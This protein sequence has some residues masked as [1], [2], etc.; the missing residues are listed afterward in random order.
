[1]NV[2]N[3]M[4][5]L[6]RG[7]NKNCTTFK[8]K[9]MNIRSKNYNRMLLLTTLMTVNSIVFGQR[10]TD[11][12]TISRDQQRQCIKWYN[13]MIYRDS[14]ILVKDQ[15][16]SLKDSIIDNRGAIIAEKTAMINVIEADKENL[17]RK[18]K[19]RNKIILWSGVAILIESIVIILTI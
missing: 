10:S 4:T 19:T 6:K 2:Q 1:M 14:I 7:I 12:V 9:S 17:Q 11:S 13:G 18:V 3:L 8:T 15:Q 5:P 16:L